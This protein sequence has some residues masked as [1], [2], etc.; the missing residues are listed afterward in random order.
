VLYCF[1][2]SQS[3][4]DFLASGSN[5]GLG[6]NAKFN[7]MRALVVDKADT[8]LYVCDFGN[9][10]IRRIDL[11]NSSYP[12]IT[13]AA[14]ISGCWGLSFDKSKQY[15]YAVASLVHVIYKVSVSDSLPYPITVSAANIIAGQ[16]SELHNI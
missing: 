15:L 8:Y 6:K 2:F 14:G 11:S 9:N 16:Y 12:V 13:V 4:N 5:D 3:Q 7:N 1:N 10:N